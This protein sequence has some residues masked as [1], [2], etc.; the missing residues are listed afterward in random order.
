MEYY[1]LIENV[2]GGL[3]EQGYNIMGDINQG[4]SPPIAELMHSVTQEENKYN[5]T[6]L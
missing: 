4:L 2:D 1:A 6:G 5:R 3:H